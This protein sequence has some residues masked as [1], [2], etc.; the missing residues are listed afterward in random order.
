MINYLGS[1]LGTEEQWELDAGAFVYSKLFVVA[2]NVSYLTL[3]EKD[4]IWYTYKDT[5]AMRRQTKQ[6]KNSLY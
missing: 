5:R 1:E 3:N 6:E 4:P 2:Y